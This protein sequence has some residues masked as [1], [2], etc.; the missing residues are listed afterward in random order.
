VE[1]RRAQRKP[2]F[3][4]RS[5]K[6]VLRQVWP[7]VWR[8][9]VSAKHGEAAPIAA[10][11]QHLGRRETRRSSADNDDVPG[12][13]VSALQGGGNRRRRLRLIFYEDP[14]IA[15]FGRPAVDRTEGG[16]VEWLAAA[17]TEAGMMPWTSYSVADDDSLGQRPA[18]VSA[19]GADGEYLLARAHE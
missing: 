12:S 19:G 16:C 6:I 15:P 14:S 18:I 1:F 13:G 2:V 4:S 7:V 3:G 11:P 5:G 8:V 9:S 10:A 17:K